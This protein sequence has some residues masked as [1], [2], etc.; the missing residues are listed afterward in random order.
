MLLPLS[1]IV[2]AM[3]NQV[4]R[5]ILVLVG[6]I[7][8]AF[9]ACSDDDSGAAYEADRVGGMA[10]ADLINPDGATVGAASF[11][12][13]P[14]GVLVTI[15]VE[16]LTPG[17]HGIH[18]HTVGACSPDFAAAGGHLTATDNAVHGLKNPE[19]TV[20]NHDNGDLPNLYAA[21]DG[22]A[23]AEYFTSLVTIFGG[24]MPALLD[25]DGA[26]LVIHEN[27][28]DHVTQPIGGAGGRV[29]CGIIR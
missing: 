4:S 14:T 15:S 10:M 25:A 6:I 13:G 23:Q 26:T 18:L 28:D 27:S 17:A 11:H 5:K 20:D 24:S 2:T 16:G 8:L 22:I 3:M 9:A 12:Q 29:A 1:S 21:A 7:C 19:R